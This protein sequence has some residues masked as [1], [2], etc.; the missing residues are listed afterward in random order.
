M[1]VSSY[2]RFSLGLLLSVDKLD[3]S[4]EI[5]SR[6]LEACELYALTVY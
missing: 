4:P 3:L 1:R 5:M 6:N 2:C